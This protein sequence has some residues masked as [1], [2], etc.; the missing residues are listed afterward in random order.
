MGLWVVAQKGNDLPLLCLAGLR[1]H[2]SASFAS[3]DSS[4]LGHGWTG[5]EIQAVGEVHEETAG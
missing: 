5:H 4:S 2:G 3:L 1:L